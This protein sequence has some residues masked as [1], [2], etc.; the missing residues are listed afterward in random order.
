MS[1]KQE[2]EFIRRKIAELQEELELL[3]QCEADTQQEG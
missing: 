3:E 1:L 2:I